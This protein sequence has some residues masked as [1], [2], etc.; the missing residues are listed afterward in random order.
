MR[1]GRRCDW[2][3]LS[4]S[5]WF[6]RWVETT[7]LLAS[8]FRACFRPSNRT[9]SANEGN[10][11]TYRGP[12]RLGRRDATTGTPVDNINGMHRP[13]PI[14]TRPWAMQMRWRELLFAHWL[15]DPSV[16]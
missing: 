15:V 4:V 10:L 9:P 12:G 8:R 14:P 1:V 2:L 11:W 13:R 3:A 7:A 16:V 5:R 6:T